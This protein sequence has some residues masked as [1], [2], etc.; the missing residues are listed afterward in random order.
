MIK[1]NYDLTKQNSV[2]LVVFIWNLIYLNIAFRSLLNSFKF[3]KR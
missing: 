1:K 2:W 3:H